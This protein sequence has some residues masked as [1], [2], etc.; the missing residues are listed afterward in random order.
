MWGQLFLS[1][2]VDPSKLL[3]LKDWPNVA[4]VKEE[5]I[6]TFVKE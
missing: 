5:E 4:S 6:F 3:I 1:S 2:Q